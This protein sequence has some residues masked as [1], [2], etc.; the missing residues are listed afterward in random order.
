MT[1]EDV[2]R[3][4]FA[5]LMEHGD[6]WPQ[7]RAVA[8][9]QIG[10]RQQQLYALAARAN[11]EYAGE[12]AVGTLVDGAADFGQM[13]PPVM[14]PEAI[15]LVEIHDPGE[16][17]WEAGQRI[18]IVAADDAHASFPP[19][20]RLRHRLLDGVGSDLDGVATIKVWYPFIPEPTDP[21]EDGTRD[22]EMPDPHSELLVVDLARD[23]A[24]KTLALEPE[25]RA[26]IVASFD[27]EEAPMLEGWL[28]HVRGYVPL[29]ARFGGTV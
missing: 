5:R 25:I 13:Q 26:A 29:E 9:R 20:A 28:E 23:Y 16:S 4:A 6:R 18:S 1:F 14:R 2:R 22:V 27:A 15:T 24:R 3:A 10:L 12:C 17:E 7:G 11:P 8:Y 19:R 21:E